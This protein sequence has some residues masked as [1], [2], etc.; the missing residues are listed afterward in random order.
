MSERKSWDVVR[1]PV[2]P[3]GH[4]VATH[5]PTA[6]SGPR[7][8]Q[9]ARRAPSRPLKEQR[10]KQRRV[11]LIV[12][13]TIIGVLLAAF[14]YIAWLPALRVNA[15]EVQGSE[16]VG[17]RAS[18][19]RAVQGIHWYGLPRN[20]IFVLP[21]SDIRNQILLDYPAISAVS[22]KPASLNTIT[23]TVTPRVSGFIWCGISVDAPPA[24]GLCFDTD[25]EGL[26][27]GAAT[28]TQTSASS[29]LRIFAPLDRELTD[30]SPVGAHVVNS[31]QIPDALRFVKAVRGLGA[32]VSVLAIKQD[33]ADLYLQGP[34]HIRYV[35]G[36]EEQ[37]I[38][39]AVSVFPTLSLTD[40]TIE[41]IDLRFV[42][43]P[44]Q[45]GKV[46]VK[47]FGE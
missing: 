16:Q 45:P 19:E 17:M 42:G 37:A 7:R 21:E 47:R 46:Y 11:F 18:A 44:G 8:T 9:P 38:Q 6:S 43:E 20:S 41:Y 3:T 36:R 15:F 5:A 35:L 22:L 10:K 32:P 13:G 12:L 34:T 33:E 24:D 26:I 30:G 39:L 1:K 31:H 23:L 25:S 29:S 28:Y 2:K 4:P 27:F 14:I 40:H